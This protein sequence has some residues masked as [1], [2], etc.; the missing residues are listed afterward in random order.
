MNDLVA[1]FHFLRPLWLLGLMPL[2]ALLW[3]LKTRPGGREIL[4][5]FCDPALLP[6][7]AAKG[8]E[9]TRH[10]RFI[11]L[12]LGGSLALTALAGP[13]WRQLP[14]PLFR[15][16][17]A[18]VIVLDLSPSMLATDLAPD[19]LTRA[20]YKI[21][22]LLA[23]RQQGQTALVVFAGRPF[24]VTPLTDD[25]NTISSQLEIM[26]PALMPVPGS[27]LLGAYQ[28][29]AALLQQAG[30]ADGDIL[31]VTDG[32]AY[33]Q[34]SALSDAVSKAHW[35]VS[36]LGM[37]TSGGAP[38]PQA[39]G[40]F[41]KDSAGSIVMAR[42]DETALRSLAAGGHGL[43]VG[44][45][46]DDADINAIHQFLQ[47][48]SLNGKTSAT[49]RVSEQW[50]ELGPWLLLPLLPLAGLAFR[51][52][53]LLSLFFIPLLL[54]AQRA[55]ALDWWFSPDQ[56]GQ[57]EFQRKDYAKAANAFQHPGW[58]GAAY[59]RQ[60]DYQ[61]AAKALNEG[62]DAESRYNLGNAL[63]RQGQ[64]KEALAA[65]DAAL[66]ENPQHDDARFN[67]S[68]IEDLL[69]K[70]EQESEKEPSEKNQQSDKQQDNQQGQQG[71]GEADKGAKPTDGQQD[72]QDAGREQPA[73]ASDEQQSGK[74]Q[75]AQQDAQS[76]REGA[77]KGN[78]AMN[79]EQ[80]K[81]A[82]EQ[83]AQ[84]AADGNSEE[85]LSSEQWLRQV[86]D[87]P[88]GLWRRKFQYQYQR[89]Y[90]GQAGSEDTW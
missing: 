61:A 57:R 24:E 87:D 51:R 18:L 11:A 81:Q 28:H 40:G 67:K 54:P 47:R 10:W 21:R 39:D 27:D 8:G 55:E 34:Q 83:A 85:K 79:D 66:K 23:A 63:A 56:A 84:A 6:F 59:Y 17:S 89:Q 41:I 82:A 5:Q 90:G 78:A 29:A 16:D 42:L 64:F 33:G 3:R 30:H 26:T 80:R 70:Q 52:G 73:E 46:N 68:L 76:G 43:Y 58:R 35:R 19:R 12:A 36:I 48:A 2:Y 45:R 14:Q 50:D 60:G 1:N 7:I 75:S 72:S 86:P 65:Y 25:V 37:G 77:G 74:E 53:M 15:E 4:R 69:R 71:E 62:S 44:V 22:D 32:V 13:T 88:G 38:V 20:R 9:E 49:R 31:L